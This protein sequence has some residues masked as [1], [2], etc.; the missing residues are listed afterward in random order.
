[1]S[2]NFTYS[3]SQPTDYH[4]CQDSVLFPKLVAERARIHAQTR[5]LDLCAGCGVI[6]FELSHHLPAL[7]S[8][9]FL[10][11]Q[12]AFLPHVEENA[13]I[14]GK[15]ARFL[16]MNYSRLLDPEFAGRYD[17]IVSNPPYFHP[18][19][20]KPSPVEINN[21]ARFFLDADFRC[22]IRAVEH[23]LVPGGEAY[24]L[25][26]PGTPHGRDSLA[27]IRSTLG[28]ATSATVIADIRGTSV[29]LLKSL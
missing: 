9:D 10:E 5:V 21:R 17:L 25:V 15:S 13:K 3:Y 4:F 16:H 19:D 20:G 24:I 6:G 18:G 8:I 29:V 26:K 2:V 23:A 1:M 11:V 27:E 12:E 28:P 7:A 22:L 14:T